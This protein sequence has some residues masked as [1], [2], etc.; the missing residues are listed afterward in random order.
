[1]SHPMLE[2]STPLQFIFTSK[3]VKLSGTVFGHSLRR[4]F[5]ASLIQLHSLL[6]IFG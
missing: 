4:S 2:V 5:T 3:T 1:M 6:S